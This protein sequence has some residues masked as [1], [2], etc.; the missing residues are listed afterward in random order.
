MIKAAGKEL[1]TPVLITNTD[2]YDSVTVTDA[3]EVKTGDPLI[4]V[5]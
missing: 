2:D 3:E 5:E 1:Y 4:T